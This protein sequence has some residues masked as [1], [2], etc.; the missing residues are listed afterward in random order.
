MLTALGVDVVPLN[1]RMDETKPGPCCKMNSG[2]TRDRVSKIVH[3]AG[4]RRGHSIRCVGGEKIF[5]VDE[6]GNM[7]D[8][9][10]TTAALMVETWRWA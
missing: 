5:L 6:Q 1:A 9:I 4:R 3:C 2:P 8:D 7:L 10:I